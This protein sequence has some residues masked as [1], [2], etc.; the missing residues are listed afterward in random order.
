MEPCTISHPPQERCCEVC[1][2]ENEEKFYSVDHIFNQC[3]ECCFEPKDYWFY[4]VFEWGLQNA[5]SDTP[6]KDLGYGKYHKTVTHGVSKFS[7][8]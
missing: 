4:K 8:T 3:G 6:C 1:S 7:A 5:E 2:N